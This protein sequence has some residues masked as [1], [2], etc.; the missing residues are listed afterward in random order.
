MRLSALPGR[1]GS[2]YWAISFRT[3]SLSWRFSQAK[4]MCIAAVKLILYF[5]SRFS[6]CSTITVFAILEQKLFIISLANISCFTDDSLFAW[7]FISPIAYLRN[8]NEVSMLYLRWYNSFSFS[9]GN[10]TG[11]R[12]IQ[13]VS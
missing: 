7:K 6:F 3:S 4:Q 11:L 10:Q 1:T 5:S 13:I 8:L 12:A 2:I 9:G